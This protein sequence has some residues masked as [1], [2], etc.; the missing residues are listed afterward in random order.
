MPAPVLVVVVVVV[1]V[2]RAL[3]PCPGRP[4]K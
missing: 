4:G 3:A 1:V 2:E